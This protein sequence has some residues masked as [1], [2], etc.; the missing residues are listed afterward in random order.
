MYMYIVFFNKNL[1]LK[2]NLLLCVGE[3]AGSLEVAADG[4]RWSLVVASGGGYCSSSMVLVT[5]GGQC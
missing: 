5:D 2:K 3:G 1:L 4:G